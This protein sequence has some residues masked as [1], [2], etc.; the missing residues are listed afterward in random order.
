MKPLPSD[1]LVAAALAA[2]R[3]RAW[4]LGL[5]DVHK[6]LIDAE[7]R[8]YERTHGPIDGPHHAF[9]LLMHDQE[10]AWLRPLADLIVQIDERLADA[11]PIGPEELNEYAARIRRRLQSQD[12]VTFGVPYRQALQDEPDVVVA[13]GTLLRLLEGAGRP[14]DL[15]PSLPDRSPADERR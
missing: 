6:F 7:R 15:R 1:A 4:R 10:F 3:L 2:A 11:G 13:H 12:P 8:R 9:R 5:L 14:A